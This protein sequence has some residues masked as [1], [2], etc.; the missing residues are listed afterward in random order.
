MSNT[1]ENIKVN[2]PRTIIKDAYEIEITKEGKVDVLEGISK[3]TNNP[4]K[5][6]K[7][8][9]WLHTDGVAY[10]SRCAIQLHDQGQVRAEDNPYAVGVYY[11]ADALMVG[12]FGD[13]QISRDL[14]LVLKHKA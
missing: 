6:V 8:E 3:R 14:A 10:P 4:F 5:I 13:L 7:Q 1:N 2:G 11:I 12:G 9:A